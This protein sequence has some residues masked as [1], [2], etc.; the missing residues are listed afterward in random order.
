MSATYGSD[1]LSGVRSRA[2]R[3]GW[4][5]RKAN[6]RR[7]LDVAV[8]TLITTYL[9]GWKRDGDGYHRDAI[10]AMMLELQQAYRRRH[11]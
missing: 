10:D 9:A 4:R 8:A 5:R 1:D 11:G 6:R 2:A 7:Q 3:V